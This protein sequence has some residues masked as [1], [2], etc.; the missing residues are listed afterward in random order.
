MLSKYFVDLEVCAFSLGS[1][2]A[3]TQEDAQTV[4]FTVDV[5]NNARGG[6]SHIA[7][8]AM[9]NYKISLRLSDVDLAAS[10]M[11]TINVPHVLAAVNEDLTV[12]DIKRI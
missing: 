6:N 4:T 7:A 1:P 11:D 8:A 2:Y 10:S 9:D 3:I 12:S 5:T